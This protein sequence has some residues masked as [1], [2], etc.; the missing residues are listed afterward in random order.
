MLG[1][2]SMDLTPMIAAINE[3]RNAV[4]NLASKSSDVMLDGQKVGKQLGTVKAL[5]TSQVQNSYKLA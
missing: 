1:G 5:G 3:V 4:N 2:G